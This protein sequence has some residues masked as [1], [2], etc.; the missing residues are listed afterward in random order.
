MGYI[1]GFDVTTGEIA[2]EFATQNEAIVR[3][4]PL[5]HEG[6]MYIG[7]WNG[8]YYA[9]DINTKQ[10]IWTKN[11]LGPFQ[12]SSAIFEDVLV[13]GGRTSAIHAVELATGVNI[14]NYY[15]GS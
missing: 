12:S 10:T 6:V 13:F 5:I 14:W 9:I 4:T 8:N 11:F 7:D 3:H 2:W 1:Y 15:V